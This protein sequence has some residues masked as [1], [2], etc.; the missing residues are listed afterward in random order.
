MNHD[1]GYPVIMGEVLFDSFPDGTEVLGGAPFNVAWHLQAFGENPLFISRVGNDP[2]GETIRTAMEK[3][4]MTTA[5]LQVDSNHPTGTVKVHLRDNEPTFEIV[6]DRAY[7]HISADMLPSV[8]ACSLLY[9][10]SLALRNA[11]SRTTLNR[12]KHTLQSAIFVDINL[13]PPWW[14]KDAVYALL[15]E[16]DWVKLNGEELRLLTIEGRDDDERAAM[17]Q[18]QC[19]ID[20]LFVTHGSE[21]ASVRTAD[22][23]TLEVKPVRNLE[24]VDTVGAGDAFASVLLLGLMNEW[25]LR[26]TME[27]AQSFATAIVGVRGATVMDRAFY[28]SFLEEWSN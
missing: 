3:W 22:G 18:K 5:G 27:R 23:N 25:P 24:V 4:G 12:L 17:L 20:L 7:D 14:K 9:H 6:A 21:G 19:E 1:K 26:L 15:K 28:K 10:G 13:R 2:L 16:A 11:E 8:T